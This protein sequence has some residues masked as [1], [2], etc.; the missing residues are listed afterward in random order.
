MSRDLLEYFVLH[1]MLDCDDS[2]VQKYLKIHPV[3]SPTVFCSQNVSQ[4]YKNFRKHHK[5]QDSLRS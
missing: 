4:I 3:I 1:M 5:V 2:T